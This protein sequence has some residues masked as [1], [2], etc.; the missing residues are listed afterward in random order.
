ML[1]SLNWIRDYVDLPTNLDPRALAEKFTRTTA[2]VD[3]VEH[4]NIGATGLIA[5]RAIKITPL[6]GKNLK[7]VELNIGKGKTIETVS[8][9][10]VMASSGWRERRHLALRPSYSMTML[11]GERNRRNCC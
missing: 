2:E 5:A 6:P 1:I 7:L 9:A 10:P 4:I 3:E 8:A 11:A